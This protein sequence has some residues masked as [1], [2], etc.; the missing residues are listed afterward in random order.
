MT[1]PPVP[2]NLIPR[3]REGPD[4]LP[5]ETWRAATGAPAISGLV[6]WADSAVGPDGLRR[7][8]SA[9]GGDEEGRGVSVPGAKMLID[10]GRAHGVPAVAQEEG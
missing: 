3:L 6:H 7:R 8:L 2:A 1:R 4:S 5:Q 9:L 10:G